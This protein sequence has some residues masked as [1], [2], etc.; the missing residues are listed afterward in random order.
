MRIANSG[1]RT[2]RRGSILPMLGVCLIGLFGFVALAVDLGMLAVARTQSQNAADVAA[3]VGTRTL[4]NKDGVLYSN[5]PLA[6]AA[7]KSSTTGNPYLSGNFSSSQITKVEAGQYLYN[8]TTQT[9]Q[10]SSWSTVTSG[11]GSSPTTGSWTALR[12]TISVP[13]PTYFMRIFGVTSMPTGAVATAVYRPRDIAFVLDMTGSMAYSSTFNN[14]SQ[15]MNPDPLVPVAGHY[16]S[17]QSVLIASA[18][19]A[20][21][22]GEAIPRNNYCIAT[23]SGPPIIRNFYFD[24]TNINAPGTVA[25]P[26][27]TK[28]DGSPN[29]LNA[30]HR[31]SPAESGADSTNY[32]AP[33]YDWTDYNPMHKGNEAPP[34]G[35]TPAPSFYASM[36]DSN[37]ITYSGDRWRRGDGKIDK[38][39]TTWSTSSTATR[40]AY[41]AADLLGYGTGTNPP[42]ASPSFA[43]GWVDFRDPLWETYGYDLD[44]NKYRTARGSGGPMNPVTYLAVN[45]LGLLNNILVPTADRFAGYSMGPGYWGKTFYIWPPDPRAP[46]GNPGDALYQAGDWRRRY[47]Y[48]T[49]GGTLDSQADNNSSNGNGAGNFDSINEVILNTTTSGQTL[50]ATSGT[51]INYTAIL[52]WIKSGPQVLP[53]NLRA[54]RVL[55]YSSIPD[56]VNTATGTTQEKFDK[57]FWKS[58]I[59]FVLGI[60]S[61]SGTGNLYGGADSWSVNTASVTT[62]D[63][64]AYNKFSWELVAGSRPYMRYTDS[65]RRPRLHMWFGP[66]S[67]VNFLTLGDVSSSIGNWLPGTCNEAHCWQLKAGMNSVLDDVKNNHPNDFAGLVFFAASQ[68][69]GVRWP[70]GQNYQALKNTLFYPKQLLATINGGNNTTE[71]RPYTTSSLTGHDDADIPNAGGSTDPQTGLAYGFNVLSPSTISAAQ[72]VGTGNG[73]RGA[74]KIIIFETDGVPN[75]YR[76]PTFVPRGYN[77]YY[78]LSGVTS[79]SNG[80]TTGINYAY[81]VIQQTVKQMAT[82]ATTSGAGADSGLS[83]PNAQARVYPIAFGD[84]FDAQLAPGATYRDTAQAFLAKCAEYGGTGTAGATTLPAAQT[85]TGPYDQRITRMRDCLERIFQSGVSVVLIE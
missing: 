29:L 77:S 50:T 37:G 13:Q 63:L 73:R 30:F 67:M 48:N 35:P 85:I 38:S 27:T 60:G 46:V 7:T 45:G 51:Q 14:N 82:T 16:T 75:S 2:D 71:V 52:K 15:S 74:Q 41:H 80:N 83:L 3:L 4:N 39:E 56:D 40:A 70:L 69:N 55:Y 49:S 47:F 8:P 72:S 65:P 18:N 57:G 24:P 5:L 62:S 33:T 43:N 76:T 21:S 36:T 81:S 64:T 78:T 53:P 44:I 66:L 58:Y 84:L 26:L 54:G 31:W 6:V 42:S 20:N 68:H 10:V 25:Y 32:V 28:A 19:L 12:V 79:A 34:K 1:H 22:N 59:D 17:R 23:P 11:A 9:F 61:Y